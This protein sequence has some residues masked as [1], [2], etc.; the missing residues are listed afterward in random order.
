L[1]GEQ[2]IDRIELD[3]LRPIQK[4]DSIES[5][6]MATNP[7]EANWIMAFDR[8][9]SNRIEIDRVRPIE[10]RF[11][12]TGCEENQSDRIELENQTR[13]SSIE[14]DGIRPIDTESSNCTITVRVTPND[15]KHMGTDSDSP[16]VF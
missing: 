3:R 4:T 9:R 8:I 14:S 10:K 2:K 13:L 11:D 15:K 6:A 16:Q 12:R 1:H 5:I 7:N